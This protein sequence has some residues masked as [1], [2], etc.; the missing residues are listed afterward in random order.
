MNS[1]DSVFVKRRLCATCQTSPLC[2]SGLPPSRLAHLLSTCC[3]Q[4]TPFSLFFFR[5]AAACS[6]SSCLL[7][8]R[9]YLL[10]YIFLP[11]LAAQDRLSLRDSR[12]L[13]FIQPDD[14]YMLNMR[15]PS[16]QLNDPAQCI[17]TRFFKHARE[18]Q[19]SCAV[20]CVSAILT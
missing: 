20:F 7:L 13:P 14:M 10:P 6:S 2:Y 8:N 12:D 18:K 16:A 19:Q 1:G 5:F 3:L 4:P 15:L 17:T 11:I 9:C